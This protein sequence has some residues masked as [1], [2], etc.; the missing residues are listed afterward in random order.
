M[1]LV[2]YATKDGGSHL[3]ALT[4]DRI[5]DLAVVARELS[6]PNDVFASMA[7]WLEAGEPC[8]AGTIIRVP[9]RREPW[10]VIFESWWL[11][12]QS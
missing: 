6:L 11:T 9:R 5:F 2:S 7:S 10:D 4:E 12:A 3:G 8:L 1:R